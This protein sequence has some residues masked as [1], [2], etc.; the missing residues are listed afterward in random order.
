MAPAARRPVRRLRTPPVHSSSLDATHA[1]FRPCTQCC[2][3]AVRQD[4]VT[5]EPAPAAV[6]CG[7][8]ASLSPTT[9]DDAAQPRQDLSST[10][11][12]TSAAGA[13]SG[14]VAVVRSPF[15]T[16]AAFRPIQ[17][18]QPPARTRQPTQHKH[19]SPCSCVLSLRVFAVD[20]EQRVQTSCARRLILPCFLLVFALA[21]VS[22]ITLCSGVA[23]LLPPS[24][25]A[26]VRTSDANTPLPVALIFSTRN[27]TEVR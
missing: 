6:K 14:K 10:E 16:H 22:R 27:A 20:G 1:P 17:E 11:R 8:P 2:K 21:L 25:T 5:A 24:W 7:I 13:P 18:N 12:F 4:S 19:S 9:A 26:A 15:R 23:A 3:Q